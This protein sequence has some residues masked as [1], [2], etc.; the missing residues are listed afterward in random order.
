[1]AFLEAV[2]WKLAQFAG[3][4]DFDDDVSGVL[5]EFKPVGTAT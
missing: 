3:R 4:D 1:M 2:V 5:L